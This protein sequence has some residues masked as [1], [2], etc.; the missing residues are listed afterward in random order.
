MRKRIVR[1]AA[2]HSES[3]SPESWL[4]IEQNATV[5]VTSEDPNFPIESLFDGSSGPGWQALE[6]G[7]QRIRLI[8]DRPISLKRIRLR[9]IETKL[10]RKQEFTLGW[11]SMEGGLLK[12][13]VRQQWNFSPAGST[14]EVEEYQTS[15]D[16][17]VVLELAIQPDLE[18]GQA[19]AKLA[20]WRIA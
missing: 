17:V 14:S 9:F 19:R 16:G 4:N 15:L 6:K 5:E 8:F 10:E 12:E 13:I 1:R 2:I 7:K 18:C 20:E 11:S 3:V